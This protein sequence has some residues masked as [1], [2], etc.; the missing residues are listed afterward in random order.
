MT[1]PT[2]S[3]RASGAQ[4]A[5][6]ADQPITIPAGSGGLLVVELSYADT[7]QTVSTYTAGWDLLFNVQQ[8]SGGN[9]ALAVFYK[10]AIGSDALTVTM[11]GNTRS[12]HTSHR[13]SG[14]EALATQLPEYA[15]AIATNSSADSPDLIPTG[16]AKDYLWFSFGASSHAGTYTSYPADFVNGSQ[17]NTGTASAGHCIAGAA[18]RELNAASLNP[19]AF[20]HDQATVAEWVAAT[21]A[22]H[23]A[24]APPAGQPFRIRTQGVPTGAGR[25]DRPSRWN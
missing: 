19:G 25:H 7:L 17:A 5:N 22:I 9:N 23:P 18:E 10:E 4:T 13:I 14:A 24:G 6:Q 2:V 1:F 12:A 3:N 20:V 8:T 11:T 15:T 16:G 21:V